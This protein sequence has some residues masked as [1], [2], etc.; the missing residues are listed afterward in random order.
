MKFGILDESERVVPVLFCNPSLG[1]IGAACRTAFLQKVA[2]MVID[3]DRIAGRIRLKQIAIAQ[4]G[5]EKD[6]K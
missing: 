6:G 2:Q 3:G 1:H 4:H 5:G